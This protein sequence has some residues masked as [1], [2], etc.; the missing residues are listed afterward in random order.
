MLKSVKEIFR[1]YAKGLWERNAQSR[2][3][4]RLLEESYFLERRS[5]RILNPSRIP[6]WIQYIVDAFVASAKGVAIFIAL[7]LFRLVVLCITGLIVAAL[8]LGF[9]YSMLTTW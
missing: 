9:F 4:T 5:R 8:L 1:F 3:T 7:S 6:N 2:R